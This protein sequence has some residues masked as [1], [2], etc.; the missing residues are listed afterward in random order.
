MVVKSN[1]VSLRHKHCP[2]ILFIHI[3]QCIR[4]V[5]AFTGNARRSILQLKYCFQHNFIFENLIFR[6]FCLILIDFILFLFN[7]INILF[8]F[9]FLENF[10][11]N[12]VHEPGSRIMSKNG[13]RNS[14][15]SKNQV[16][17]KPSARAPK[18][19][20]LGHPRCALARPGACTPGR[21]VG[22]LAVSWPRPP[23]VS[24][25]K[26]PCRRAHARAPARGSTGALPRAPARLAPR[27]CASCP[28]CRRP[29]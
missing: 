20:Q 26:P 19:A 29:P 21:I 28:A 10:V 23:A 1:I 5:L 12:S 14:T 18:L 4:I 9:L 27:P 11:M 17:T 2:E 22:R 13:L 6:K 16:K 25:P 15:E 7:L 8:L 3:N 24:Q